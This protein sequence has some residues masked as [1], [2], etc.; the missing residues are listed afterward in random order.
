MLNVTSTKRVHLSDVI[1]LNE[2][3]T[4]KINIVEAPTGAGKTYA[5]V[6]EFRKLNKD[7]KLLYLIDTNAGEEN[8][9]RSYKEIDKYDQ[10]AVATIL[11][12][13]KEKY[14][15]IAQI[16][17]YAKFGFLIKINM[18]DLSEYGV[19]VCDEIHSLIKFIKWERSRLKKALPFASYEDSTIFLSNNG[20][21]NIAF[22][23][24]VKS[25]DNDSDTFVIG[26]TATPDSVYKEIE[27]CVHVHLNAEVSRYIEKEI[28]YYTS[29]DD[30]P[31]L[32]SKNEKTLIYMSR[33]KCMK[34]IR[35]KI[36]Q[37]GISCECL[38][39]TSAKEK[40]SKGQLELREQILT[41][42]LLPKSLQVLIINQAYETCVNIYDPSINTVIVH[43]SEKDDQIQAR[44]RVRH[45]IDML[46]IFNPS[47]TI[48]KLIPDGYLNHVLSKEEKNE[49]CAYMNIKDAKGQL[50]KWPY[51]VKHLNSEIYNIVEQRSKYIIKL[52]K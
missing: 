24:L 15:K 25:A 8:I 39:S 49:I 17:T 1:D 48:N 10:K 30:I 35:E 37:N 29:I 16:M 5:A 31:K 46:Y 36:N 3:S 6:N 7:K 41:A 43:T 2:F 18:I 28:R 44:G 50:K 51:I 38:W 11:G 32:I 34:D 27:N 19:I 13:E 42:G 4:D 26:M 23:N 22:H 21:A 33:I 45:D 12:G 14:E 20:L 47:E 9:L 52:Q 40:M